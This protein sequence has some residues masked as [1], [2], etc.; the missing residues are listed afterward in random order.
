MPLPP[1][2]DP[3][4]QPHPGLRIFTFSRDLHEQDLHPLR[5]WCLG[6]CHTVARVNGRSFYVYTEGITVRRLVVEWRQWLAQTQA[7]SWAW[8]L[9][10]DDHARGWQ[11]LA[12]PAPD[13]L[14]GPGILGMEAGGPS[15]RA[16]DQRTPRAEHQ[17]LAHYRLERIDD[18]SGTVVV[19][20]TGGDRAYTVVI[21]PVWTGPPRCDCP[22]ATQRLDL[23]G[24]HCKH[25]IAALLRWPDL[26]HRLL[27]A[28]L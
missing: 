8:M 2:V 13:P 6:T 1:P 9:V 14:S 21:D 5:R 15:R 27:S 22:D 25:A 24:G 3:P 10:D 26:R 4:Q 28:L 16:I 23:H 19:R 11:R 20:A 7:T 18:P 17:V 12:P